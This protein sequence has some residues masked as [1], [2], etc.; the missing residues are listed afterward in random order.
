MELKEGTMTESSGSVTISTRLQQVAELARRM[1]E[2]ALTTLAHHI[3]LDL[4]REAYRLTRKDGAA[5]VDG[6]SAQEYAEALDENLG[7]LLERAKSGTYRAPPVRRVEIP[8]GSSGKTRPIG[9][10]T[11]EDKVLQRA[12]TMVLGAVYEE[13]FLDCSYGFRPGRS[14]HQALQRLWD[15]LMEMGGGW[16]LEL[17]IEDFFGSLDREHLGEIL[18]RRVRDG[19]LLRLIGKWLR[20]GALEEGRLVLSDSGTPQGGVISPLLANVYLHEVLDQWF[21]EDVLPRLGAGA[22]MVRFA[23]DAVLVFATQEDARR[24]AEVLPKRCAKYGLRL[25]PEKT[26][27]V[28]F[29][30]PQP[31]KPQGDRPGTFDFL[32]FTHSW[33]RSRRGSP[34][35]RRKTARDR[36]TRS[37]KAVRH[38]CRTHRHDPVAEQRRALSRK[39]MGHYAYYGIT[40]NG[41]SLQRFHYEVLQAWRKWLHRRSNRARMTWARFGNLLSHHPLP[42]PRVVHSVYR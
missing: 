16:V 23:D 28:R 19:V 14:A 11:F 40:G 22:F 13:D 4:L 18:R 1:P 33:G 39:L 24:V 32:G 29:G 31:R 37:L 8:K 34:V 5:G 36:L 9:V 42:R 17:D 41:A 38:W 21:A 35:V 27:L 3:D 7:D 12:V 15:G 26:R 25:H 20:A 6:Q 30:R 2:A 10:P